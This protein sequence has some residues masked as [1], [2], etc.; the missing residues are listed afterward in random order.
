METY[1]YRN[2]SSAFIHFYLSRQSIKL[3]ET[4]TECKIFHCSL[5]LVLKT[6]NTP[7]DI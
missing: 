1:S 4:L 3:T 5:S 6:L 7:T 2:T